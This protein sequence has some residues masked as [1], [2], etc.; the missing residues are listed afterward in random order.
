VLSLPLIEPPALDVARGD[1]AVDAMV[2]RIDELW[3]AESLEPRAF[4]EEFL[5]AVGSS[6]RLTDEL[7]A[8]LQRGAEL[9]LVE[10]LPHEARIP[11]D[12]LRAAGFPVLVVSGGHSATF[13]AVCDVLER[14]LAA[15][16]VVLPGAGH[17]VQRAPGFDEALERFLLAAERAKT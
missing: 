5:A 15:E 10:R 14:E 11:L 6:I 1:P 2:A 4:L 16:R 3:G 17:T 9:L 12:P 7:P 8:P 13:D